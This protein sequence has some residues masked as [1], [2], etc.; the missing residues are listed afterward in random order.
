VAAKK[1]WTTNF[2]PPFLLLYSIGDLRSGMDKN[3]YPG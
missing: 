3:Q 2:P 1:D